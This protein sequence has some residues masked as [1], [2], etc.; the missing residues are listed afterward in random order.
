MATEQPTDETH[1]SREWAGGTG[2]L[3]G[4]HA[5]DTADGAAALWSPCLP[6]WWRWVRG[7]SLHP[8][9]LGIPFCEMKGL[10]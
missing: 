5:L 7:G 6:L 10:A 3:S 9:H 4:A 8:A 1:F 2:G